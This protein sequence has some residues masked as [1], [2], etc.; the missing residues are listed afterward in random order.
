MCMC[1]APTELLVETLCQRYAKFPH[2]L[3][4]EECGGWG[5]PGRKEKQLGLPQ[6]DLMIYETE[7][8]T[9]T[10]NHRRSTG[11]RRRVMKSDILA[12]ELP[13][14]GSVKDVWANVHGN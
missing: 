3:S 9:L 6:P 8:P 11:G 7:I 2:F 12:E 4:R 10:F 1:I 14:W 5:E 13:H